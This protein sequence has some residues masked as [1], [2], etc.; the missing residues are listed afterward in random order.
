MGFLPKQ[1][2]L[3]VVNKSFK[4]MMDQNKASLERQRVRRGAEKWSAYLAKFTA[5]RKEW[6]MSKLSRH[7]YRKMVGKYDKNRKYTMLSP[8]GAYNLCHNIDPK[9]RES[10]W[11]AMSD[12]NKEEWLELAAYE[13]YEYNK[14]KKE[15]AEHHD[16]A[17]VPLYW[18][19]EIRFFSWGPHDN[20]VS[21]AASRFT[22]SIGGT[23]THA[24]PV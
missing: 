7:G 17:R 1:K 11:D 10:K 23:T 2:S 9:I 15:L 6:A 22:F 13:K 20:A 16:W 4:K 5:I 19:E 12:A 24:S 3:R 21:G 18:L 8:S 14:V